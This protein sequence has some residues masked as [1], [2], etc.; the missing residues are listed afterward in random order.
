MAVTH[1]MSAAL[2]AKVETGA[3]EL[4]E[5]CEIDF[6]SGTVRLAPVPFTSVTNGHYEGKVIAYGR[7]SIVPSDRS[8]AMPALET[9]LDV[10]DSDRTVGRLMGGADA[11][12]L[13]GSACR[14]YLAHP[15]VDPAD[16]LSTFTGVI[17]KRPSFPSHG[18]AR[19]TARVDDAALNAPFP[20]LALTVDRDSW[21]NAHADAIGKVV[22]IVFGEHSCSSYQ[23]GPGFLPCLFV[24]VPANTY[25]PS[26]GCMLSVDQVFADGVEVATGWTW[27][28]GVDRHG[29]RCTQI[30]FDSDDHADAVITC[31][32]SG[33]EDVGDGSGAL[34]A[35]PTDQLSHL[36]SQFVFGSW[37]SGAWL[38][39]SDKI[40]DSLT[41]VASAFLASRQP[42]GSPCYFARTDGYSV[43]KDW[44]ESHG[45]LANWSPAG[46]I[47]FCVEDVSGSPYD[48]H[49][50]DWDR[51]VSSVSIDHDDVSET[52][53]I[54]VE[55]VRSSS[56]DKYVSAFEVSYP[57][58]PVVEPE[59][60]RLVWAPAS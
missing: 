8:G 7:V 46:T 10:D 48:G 55:H 42:T 58:A 23:T 29:R 52:T 26:A 27:G 38:A 31:N 12:R 50:V 56:E 11:R 28:Y 24:N 30:T 20:P 34:I 21:P 25:V 53:T 51:D 47:E 37:R 32:G 39:A 59:E 2:R 13:V 35:S 18:V 15:D 49:E 9:T 3:T 6:P 1:Q 43:I 40:G 36:L 19:I 14:R 22:P 4:V 57:D 60:L 44:C 33:L 41:D 5:V 17:T 54:R 45:V 16:W